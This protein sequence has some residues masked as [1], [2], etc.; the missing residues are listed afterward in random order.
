[1][2]DGYSDILD[3][4]ALDALDEVTGGDAE[5]MAELVDTFLEDAPI[6]IGDMWQ[7]LEDGN[8]Q[9]VRRLSHGL[10]SNGRDF[11]ATSFADMCAELEH[12][13]ADENLSETEA[14]LKSIETEFGVVRDA[15]I[16]Y[17]NS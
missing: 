13:S 3:Q 14:L 7:A 10:K 9:E 1:M 5:F 17:I 8:A 15:L 4:E 11:G 16:A 2:S 12:Q 6:L